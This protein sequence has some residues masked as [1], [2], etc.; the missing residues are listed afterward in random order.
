MT[1]L[2]DGRDDDSDFD[3][4]GMDMPEEDMVFPLSAWERASPSLVEQ[5]GEGLTGDKSRLSKL[6]TK[7]QSELSSLSA[8]F[9]FFT[10][11]S[12]GIISCPSQPSSGFRS[13]PLLGAMTLDVTVKVFVVFFV[14]TEDGDAA[15][16]MLRSRLD[17]SS[18]ILL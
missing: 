15:E 8:S 9:S 4:F 3:F 13:E 16:P 17:S 12:G 10:T 14:G 18:T 1:S 5:T 7:I 2:R 6:S 11:V